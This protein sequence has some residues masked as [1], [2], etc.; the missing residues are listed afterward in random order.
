MQHFVGL[1]AIIFAVLAAPAI[2]GDVALSSAVFVEKTVDA[3]GQRR[4]VL[5]PPR[6]VAPGDK[7]VFVVNYRNRGAAPATD[8]VVTNPMPGAVAYQSSAGTAAIVSIDG[9]RNWGPLSRLRVREADGAVRWARP[10]DVTHVRWTFAKAIPAGQGG[11]LS[12][13]GVVR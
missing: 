6:Q 8:L 12:F 5:E 3:N 7:L 13:R 4:I 1:G 2:A 11:R 9:G 10:E